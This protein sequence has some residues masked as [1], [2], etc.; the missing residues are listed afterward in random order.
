MDAG[1]VGGGNVDVG[2]PWFLSFRGH[3]SGRGIPNGGATAQSWTRKGNLFH[4]HP[5]AAGIPRSGAE[6]YVVV[7][8]VE[9]SVGFFACLRRL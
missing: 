1:D 6:Q 7:T 9:P 8:V 4:R 3:A 2:G 5:R